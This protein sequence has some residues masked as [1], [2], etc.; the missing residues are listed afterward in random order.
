MYFANNSH[1]DIWR[2]CECRN[3]H[4]Y[5]SDIESCPIHDISY[6][7]NDDYNSNGNN[8]YILDYLINPKN[9]KCNFKIEKDEE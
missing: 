8:K 1:F 6:L 7:L 5:N 3:C 9:H 4:Y 2:N